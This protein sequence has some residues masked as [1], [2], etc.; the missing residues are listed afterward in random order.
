MLSRE[1]P[2]R[3][4]MKRTGAYET[5]SWRS[6]PNTATA[7]SQRST[8][9]RTAGGEGSM[10]RPRDSPVDLLAHYVIGARIAG[11][12]HRL[13]CDGGGEDLNPSPCA[14]G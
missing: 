9:M 2:P 5:G 10:Y 1:P 6:S 4:P 12:V 13:V 11:H 8:L 7:P 14:A 3:S